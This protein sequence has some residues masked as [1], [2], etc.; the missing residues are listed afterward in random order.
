VRGPGKQ[1]RIVSILYI[2]RD[3]GLVGDVWFIVTSTLSI[4]VALDGLCF[5]I[6]DSIRWSP[7]EVT[8]TS[9]RTSRYDGP[10]CPREERR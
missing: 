2:G 7:I 5:W 8:E 6:E 3:R 9:A 10:I 4:E 1:M